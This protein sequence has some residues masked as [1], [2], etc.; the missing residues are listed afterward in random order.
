[1]K[2]NKDLMDALMMISFIILVLVGTTDFTNMA[3]KYT[4]MGVCGAV[5]ALSVIGRIMR[6]K[7]IKEE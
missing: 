6:T 7:K 4:L 3:Y 5:V 1:M 2:I